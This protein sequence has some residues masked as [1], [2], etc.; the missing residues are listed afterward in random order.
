[1]QTELSLAA[2]PAERR[3]IWRQLGRFFLIVYAATW[4]I[5]G[6]F[7]LFPGPTQ[8]LFGRM[9]ARHPA[10]YLAV[11]M[12][13]LAAIGLTLAEGGPAT[14]A[15]FASVVRLGRWWPYALLALGFYPGLW[16]VETLV[17]SA[18]GLVPADALHLERWTTTL[19]LLLLGGH[20]LRDPG[21]LGEE[22]GWRG[23][24]LPRL[25]RLMPARSAALLLGAVWAVWHLPAF[26]LPGLSQSAASMLLFLPTVIC[27][28]LFMTGLFVRA[29]GSVLIAGILPHMMF[30]ATPRA[31][32]TPDPWLLFAVGLAA[33]LLL[34]PTLRGRGRQ[35]A[36]TSSQGTFA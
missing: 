15:L 34:G 9:T 1:M 12:P 33:L 8:E 24:A 29:G 27:F 17:R 11:Y 14:R 2:S 25:L 30:N 5:C 4:S 18:L 26:F 35:Q 36:G 6:V 13:T 23:Y 3:H 20:L 28:S 21:A 31:G 10:F 22:L 32:I 16:L 7:I 19:P